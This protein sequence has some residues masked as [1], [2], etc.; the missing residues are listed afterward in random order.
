MVVLAVG[1]AVIGVFLAIQ[2]ALG[3]MPKPKARACVE[4][5]VA[6]HG[7]TAFGHGTRSK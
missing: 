2:Q 4:H 1:L 5:T 7:R 3:A 6:K